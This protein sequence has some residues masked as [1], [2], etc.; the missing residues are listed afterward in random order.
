MQF[1]SELKDKSSHT[2]KAEVT[3]PWKEIEQAKEKAL[4]K[5]AKSAEVKGFRKG[6]APLEVVKDTLGDQ[7]LLEEASTEVLGVVYQELIKE[8]SLKPFSDPKI[9]LLKAPQGGDWQFRF[10]IAQMPKINKMPDYRK[11][12]KDVAGELK[13]EDIWVP[14]KDGQKKPEQQ[15][16][17]IKNKKIQLILNKI[18]K[19][20]EIEIS[21]L[22]LDTEVARRLTSLY[23]EIKQLGLSVE[24][25]LQSK[26]LT[27]QSLKEKIKLETLDLY[28]SELVLDI[29]ADKEKITVEEKDLQAIYQQAK[30]EKE[31]AL[32]Q[33]NSYLYTRLLRKQKTLDFL[34]DL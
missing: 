7:K 22:V 30:D 18:L 9:T 1:T 24:Q 8:H 26:K 20:T 13:K 34:S 19:D 31:K 6:K 28:K 12:A 21:P 16:N 27:S 2:F 23:E 5:L 14:G 11:I 32:Y 15:A 4:A 29:I 3:I 33:K 17:D 10:E 25:Y